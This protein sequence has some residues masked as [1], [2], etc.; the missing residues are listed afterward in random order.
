MYRTGLRKRERERER[1]RD[2]GTHQYRKIDGISVLCIPR[3]HIALS[4]LLSPPPPPPPPPSTVTIV[5]VKAA[6]GS[7]RVEASGTHTTP[8]QHRYSGHAS[9]PLRLGHYLPR[10]SRLIPLH[11]SFCPFLSHQPLCYSPP[12]SPPPHPAVFS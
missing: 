1:E 8:V 9:R 11:R 4:P 12:S 3:D 10:S 7:K 6:S 2:L 5:F